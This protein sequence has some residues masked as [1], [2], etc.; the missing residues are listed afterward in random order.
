MIHVRE[1]SGYHTISPRTDAR[2]IDARSTDGE[3]DGQRVNRLTDGVSI[4]PV[5]THAD[6]GAIVPFA[7]NLT[8]ADELASF[9]TVANTIPAR[10]S[11]RINSGSRSPSPAH[12]GASPRRYVL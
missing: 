10:A 11:S 5:T 9:L 1:R 6:A 2:C 12:R 7:T 3:T 8:I 4:K